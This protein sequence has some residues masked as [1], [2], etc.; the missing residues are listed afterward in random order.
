MARAVRAIAVALAS[1][2]VVVGSAGGCASMASRDDLEIAM[3]QHHIDLRWG[4][5]ENAATHVAPAM[6]AA[7]LQ[8]WAARLQDVELQD[9]EVTG[10]A[11]ADDG[12]SADVVVAVVFVDRA[13]MQVRNTQLTE[14]WVRG[15]DG[16]TAA[17]P[18]TLAAPSTE[19]SSTD[20]MALPPAGDVLTTP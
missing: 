20:P 10:L 6:R 14:R 16:W 3:A 1:S 18:A 9:I 15:A 13:T 7:F 5:L 12:G 2:L 4:R 8:T 11:M 17:T 19:A